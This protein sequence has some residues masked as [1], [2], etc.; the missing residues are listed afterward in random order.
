MSITTTTLEEIKEQMVATI[1]NLTP[2]RAADKKFDLWHPDHDLTLIDASNVGA[3]FRKFQITESGDIEKPLILS[4]DANHFGIDLEILV[5]YPV[6]ALGLYATSGAAANGIRDLEATMRADAFSIWTALANE[7]NFV[8]GSTLIPDILGIDR[9]REHIWVLPLLVKCQWYQ[10]TRYVI[11]PTPSAS[12]TPLVLGTTM[13]FRSDFGI[14]EESGSLVSGWQDISGDEHHTVQPDPDSWPALVQSIA[15]GHSA[16]R[17][18][19][20]AS[21]KF[22]PFVDEWPQTEVFSLYAV[23]RFVRVL[24]YQM[25]LYSAGQTPPARAY[26]GSTGPDLHKPMA[27]ADSGTAT[28]GAALTDDTIYRIRWVFDFLTNIVSV[29]VNGASAVVG[30]ASANIIPGNW[31]SIGSAAGIHDCACDVLELVGFPEELDAG[32]ETT[33][34]SYL[35]T[36]YA[37]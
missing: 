1:R 34:Q 22:L 29:S 32:D 21:D 5:A 16:V 27:Y 17:F 31:V 12:E 28:W 8:A 35:T 37:L 30:N 33:M 11:T 3:S 7:D 18:G 14:T 9:S 13:W 4:A 6:K 2:P 15:N 25:L 10:S 26:L 36:R 19:P 20:T 23:V 24:D